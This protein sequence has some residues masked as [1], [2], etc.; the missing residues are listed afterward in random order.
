M[1]GVYLGLWALTWIW[2]VSQI[3]GIVLV[4]LETKVVASSKRLTYNAD[5]TRPPVD[6][7]WHCATGFA[8]CPFIVSVDQIWMYQHLWGDNSRKYHFW[9][10][11]FHTELF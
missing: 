7:P 11:G 8:L 2:G 9:F 6:P 1:V 10:L 4:E 3:S 5:E